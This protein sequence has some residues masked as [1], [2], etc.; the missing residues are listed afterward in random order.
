[1]IA[2]ETWLQ[3]QYPELAACIRSNGAQ[4]RRTLPAKSMAWAM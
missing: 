4:S 2:K 1:M 3:V